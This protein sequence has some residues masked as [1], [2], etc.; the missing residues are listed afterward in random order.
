[1]R[2]RVRLP[3]QLPRNRIIKAWIR[4][5]TERTERFKICLSN[6]ELIIYRSDA[7]VAAGMLALEMHRKTAFFSDVEKFAENLSQ[8]P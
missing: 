2:S 8:N 4:M 5:R 6:D 7:V 1:M 3:L